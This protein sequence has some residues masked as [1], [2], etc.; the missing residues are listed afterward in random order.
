MR[1]AQPG[2][3]A[4][5]VPEP[6]P[7]EGG[8]RGVFLGVG[9][10]VHRLLGLVRPPGAQRQIPQQ[11]GERGGHRG[12]EGEPAAGRA[13]PAAV[14]HH[15]RQ[16]TQPGVPLGARARAR[17]LPGDEVEG[18]L[19]G[20]GDQQHRQGQ[21]RQP[22][23]Q[24]VQA[25][26]PGPAVRRGPHPVGEVDHHE[27]QEQQP[28][29]AG[30]VAGGEVAPDVGLGHRPA[31]VVLGPG[32]GVGVLGAPEDGRDVVAGDPH[33]PRVVQH[34]GGCRA[35]HSVDQEFQGGAGPPVRPVF[36]VAWSGGVLSARPGPFLRL[37]HCP[38]LPR[39][40]PSALS[41]RAQGSPLSGRRTP[42]GTESP[43]TVC[44]VTPGRGGGDMCAAGGR[45]RGPWRG[46]RGW[47]VHAPEPGNSSS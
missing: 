4:A 27:R 19:A 31:P 32:L 25:Y 42:L 41:V 43:R 13:P 6:G 16:E 33:G 24:P 18:D 29:G 26:R 44:R 7:A 10:A 34:L 39:D 22:H 35:A 47:V 23:Q 2:H 8:A 12:R 40:A 15:R 17:A 9:R 37:L 5:P 1:G 20:P 45:W 30:A 46:V 14:R 38:A 21:P 36:R 11:A 3:Q 28:Q